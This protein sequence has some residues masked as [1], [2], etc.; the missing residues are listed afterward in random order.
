M[1]FNTDIG[2][3]QVWETSDFWSVCGDPRPADIEVGNCSDIRVYGTYIETTAVTSGNYISIPIIVHSAGTYDIQV[4]PVS[5]NGYYFAISGTFPTA[6]GSNAFVV[7]IPAAGKPIAAQTDHLKIT[8]NGVVSTTCDPTLVVEPAQPDYRIISVT[9]Y[10]RPFPIATPLVYTP[11]QYY[12][13]VKLSVT[14][15]GT[16]NMSSGTVNGYS[17]A[18]SGELSEA[19]GYNTN[20]HFPQTVEVMVPVVAGG[21]AIAYNSLGYDQFVMSTNNSASPSTYPFPVYL[22]GVGFTL[23]CSDIALNLGSLRQGQ[24]LTGTETIVL[25]NVTVNSPGETVITATFAGVRFTSLNASNTLNSGN[26]KTVL[27]STT[28][29][30][31]LTP[32]YPNQKPS[33]SGTAI[34]VF[35]ESSEGGIQNSCPLTV[36][37]NAAIAKISNLKV[38]GYTNNG[39]YQLDPYDLSSVPCSVILAAEVSEAGAYTLESTHDNGV[40][41]KASGV[42]TAGSQAITLVPFQD[43]I[44]AFPS[45]I[46]QT[47]TLRYDKDGNGSAND[48]GDGQLTFTIN[49]VYRT[50]NILSIGSRSTSTF[51]RPA[52]ANNGK[53]AASVLLFNK[54]N[55]G[56]GGV[57]GVQSINVIDMGVT[58]PGPSGR[59]LANF[60]NTN[61]IDVIFI[62]GHLQTKETAVAEVLKDF[63][64]NCQGFLFYADQYGSSVERFFRTFYN[65]NSININSR[66]ISYHPIETAAKSH[67]ILKGPFRDFSASANSNNGFGDDCGDGTCIENFASTSIASSAVLISKSSTNDGWMFIDD[68]KH[69]FY[70]GDYAWANGNSSYQN[71]AVA[72]PSSFIGGSPAAHP[73]SGNFSGSVAGGGD[74]KVYNSFMYANAMAYA[75]KQAAFNRVK[76]ATVA[77]P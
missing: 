13:S 26:T 36:N 59:D 20:G 72:W 16:W 3:I 49:Y 5:Q 28:T 46:K 76:T 50:I 71:D 67:D 14:R 29:T 18:G 17:F 32:E 6:S 51:D 1:V 34:P 73:L 64:T 53:V 74:G 75:I 57:V 22:A 63:V 31:T 27:S 37:I 62:A 7:N 24:A 70:C 2:C 23:S 19:S 12:A 68:S 10:P 40:T 30:I 42:L 33:Q 60:I 43:N 4:E 58:Y 35:I 11:S 61:K 15:P 25:S 45:N 55:F 21:Q 8:L 41:Y 66:V 9:A 77:V 39:T 54:E 56:P 65:D 38:T 47:Y 52:A 48:P 44:P 69:L